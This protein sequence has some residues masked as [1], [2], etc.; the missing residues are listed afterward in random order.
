MAGSDWLEET[1]DGITVFRPSRV[2][3][4]VLVTFSGRGAAP[5]SEA[6]PTGFLGRRFAAALGI[7]G[8]PLVR[9]RQVHGNR[10]VAIRETPAERDVHDVGQ[11]DALATDL[12]GVGLIVQTADCV[13]IVLAG[14]RAIGIVHA[15]WRG[16]A[17]NAAAAGVAALVELGDRQEGLGAWLGPSIGAC[18]YEVGGEVAAQ[19]AG[20]LVRG[21]WR[22]KIR[23]LSARRTACG[24][25]DCPR[26]QEVV[27][28]CQLSV[29]SYEPRIGTEN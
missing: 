12:T 8:I 4:G 20:Q 5:E 21:R 29:I 24:K 25:D 1:K 23:E 27:V 3:T 13:P 19:F 16:S 14:Q 15:G 10:A 22:G 11:C 9:A 17:K 18:C 7:P 28:S 6:S 2:P 26:C